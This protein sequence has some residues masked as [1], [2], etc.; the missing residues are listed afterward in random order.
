MEQ[1][2]HFSSAGLQL[3]G[4]LH[5]PTDMQ[6]DERRLVR[7]VCRRARANPPWYD[8]AN[9]SYEALAWFTVQRGMRARRIS[10]VFSLSSLTNR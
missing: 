8:F 10:S 3:A 1:R 5:S 6:P 2:V 7:R 9:Y 4:I